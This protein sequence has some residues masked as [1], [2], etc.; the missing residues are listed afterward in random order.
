[1][2]QSTDLLRDTTSGAVPDQFTVRGGRRLRG[3]VAVSGFKHSLV[4]A[5]AA[6]TAADAPLRLHNCPALEE[7]VVL[8]LLLRQLGGQAESIDGTLT[9]DAA[10]IGT[11]T[12]QPP[13]MSVD[14]V[15]RIHGSVY[16]FPALL[17]R[18]GSIRMLEAGGCRIGDDAAGRRPVAHY[19]EVFERFGAQSIENADGVM[20]GAR[21][22]R[23]TT[24]DMVDFMSDRVLRTGPLY[25]GATKAAL[26]TA[27]MAHGTSVVRSPYP[28]PDVTELVTVLRALG[29]AIEQTADGAYVVEG[30]G[31]PLPG[32]AA[33][34]LLIP[35][36]IAV[37]T[38][39][40]AAALLADEPLTIIAARMPDARLALVPELDVLAAMGVWTE[41]HETSCV[42]HPAEELRPVDVL[43]ASHGVFSDSQP[44]LA[45]LA[46]LAPG[47]S[48]IRDTVWAGRF[49]YAA[50]FAALGMDVEVN[51]SRMRIAG[52]WRSR[53]AADP[54]HALDLRAAAAL[55]LA[56][57]AV[58]GETTLTGMRH[59]ARGYPDL[60]GDLA[61]LGAHVETSLP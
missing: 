52:P 22:L 14:D 40:C 50:G 12:T 19:I 30:C 46:A 17:G 37:V 5:V 60:A 15:S 4:S 47:R 3:T 33:E 39:I 61:R 11:G 55:L 2:R 29:V 59:L 9:V 6:A 32:P 42:V 54:L 35:D 26:L 10:G 36:L 13:G 28:K 20:V 58:P 53:R 21:R 24:I 27:A 41:W 56:A 31:G 45:L 18:C 1:M 25:S 44:L 8:S 51:G 7:S 23:G 48:S 57:L 38:W 49:T 34:H 16:L 43:A